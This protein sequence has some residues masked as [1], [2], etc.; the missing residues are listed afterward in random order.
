MRA[1]R[2]FPLRR[3]RERERG[4]ERERE[5]EAAKATTA[6]MENEGDRQTERE[7]LLPLLTSSFRTIIGSLEFKNQRGTD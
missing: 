1:E 4:R 5:R 2:S 6:M 3:E 7:T